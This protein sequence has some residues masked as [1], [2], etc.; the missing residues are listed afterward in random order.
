MSNP[1]LNPSLIVGIL[2]GKTRKLESNL[3]SGDLSF[4]PLV[5]RSF[6]RIVPGPSFKSRRVTTPDIPILTY[7]TLLGSLQLLRYVLEWSVAK[8]PLTTSQP[9]KGIQ[10]LLLN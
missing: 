2:L 3:I 4:G 10:S 1:T 9:Y 6:D 8:V 7:S 5:Q